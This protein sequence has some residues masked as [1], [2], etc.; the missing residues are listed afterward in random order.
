MTVEPIAFPLWLPIVFVA[1]WIL[2]TGL[3]SE[4]SGWPRLARRF[5]SV[6][7]PDGR[8]TWGQVGRMGPVG[9]RNVTSFI[10]TPGG[11]YLYA[12][13]LFRFRRPPILLPW[14]EVQWL[15]DRHFLWMHTHKLDLGHGITTMSVGDRGYRVM[16]PFVRPGSQGPATQ[17]RGASERAGHAP[18]EPLPTGYRWH[19]RYVVEAELAPQAMGRAYKVADTTLHEVVAIIVLAPTLRDQEGVMRFRMSFKEAR[20]RHPDTVHDY[21]EFMGVPWVSM[22]Y[23]AGLGAALDIGTTDREVRRW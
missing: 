13:P 2:I 22:K 9:E 21:G 6:G 10:A 16:E 5:P 12:N 3:L 18:P 7:R 11:L 23:V 20:S 17:E 1:W 14:E 4:V 8:A 19:D 15:S